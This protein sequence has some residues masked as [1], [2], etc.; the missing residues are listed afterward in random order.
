M[1]KTIL[2]TDLLKSS[3]YRYCETNGFPYKEYPKEMSKNMSV[4]QSAEICS[5]FLKEVTIL[6]YLPLTSVFTISIFNGDDLKMVIPF[7]RIGNRVTMGIVGMSRYSPIFFSDSPSE[8]TDIWNDFLRVVKVK[9][10]VI[11]SVVENSLTD[12][13]LSQEHDNWAYTTTSD[14]SVVLDL[15]KY[16]NYDEFLASLSKNVRQNLRT[17]YNRL[18]TD[19]KAVSFCQFSG[20]NAPANLKDRLLTI[21]MKR[22]ETKY[23]WKHSPFRKPFYSRFEAIT[24]CAW[25]DPNT[26]TSVLFIDGEAAAFHISFFDK[27]AKSMLMPRLAIDDKYSRYSPGYL[28]INETIKAY[29]QNDDVRYFDFIRGLERYKL[30]FGGTIYHLLKYKIRHIKK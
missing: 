13:I 19:G 5:A 11:E 12:T 29:F 24:N 2:S 14:D 17:K 7:I 9:E 25:K 15:T 26:V 6:K 4:Y 8:L 21:Y 3:K 23:K 1:F 30:D 20:E 10:I 16:N 27:N 18:N 28:L 22:L